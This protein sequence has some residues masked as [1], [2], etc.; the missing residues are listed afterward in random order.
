MGTNK[1]IVLICSVLCVSVAASL[2]EQDPT[3]NVFPPLPFAP[4]D[5]KNGQCSGDSKAYVENLRNFT[6]W[7]HQSKYCTRTLYK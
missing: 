1:N 4:T 5:V 6:F 3:I 7:A 2:N